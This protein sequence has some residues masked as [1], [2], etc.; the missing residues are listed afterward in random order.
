MR[1][2]VFGRQLGRDAN[3]RKALFKS[4]ASALVLEERIAT[5]HAKAKAVRPY[6]EKLVTKA[7]KGEAAL[8][9]LEPYLSKEAAVKM[10]EKIGPRFSKR[11]GGYTRIVFAGNRIAD[12]ASMA[13]IE[14]VEKGQPVAASKKAEAKPASKTSAKRASVSS[15]KRLSQVER[16]V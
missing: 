11:N 15:T 12:N 4:L 14:F 6:V 9:L 5:T 16:K 1:K 10:V 7:R 3:E 13:V 8:R 2:N